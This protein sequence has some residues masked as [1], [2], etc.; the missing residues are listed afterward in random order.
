MVHNLKISPCD[1]DFVGTGRSRGAPVS[2]ANC[3]GGHAGFPRLGMPYDCDY[4]NLL[5]IVG[6]PG[7]P[8]HGHYHIRACCFQIGA[9]GAGAQHTPFLHYSRLKE[10]Q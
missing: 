6:S 7:P 8:I 4:S 3:L 1:T 2:L 9:E 10:G 5:C